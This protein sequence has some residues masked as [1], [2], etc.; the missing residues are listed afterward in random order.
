VAPVRVQVA[1]ARAGLGSRRACDALVAQG[2]VTVNG[3]VA[4]LGTKADPAVDRIL[5]RGKPLRAASRLRYVV[6]FKPRGLVTTVSDPEGRPTVMDL[7]AGIRERLHPV[8]RLDVQT[9]GLLLLTNDGPL[10]D[11]LTHPRHGVTKTYLAKVSG[12]LGANAVRRLADGIPLHG[13]RTA[14]IHVRTLKRAATSSWVEVVV[15]EGRKHLVREVL[16]A[17]GHPVSKLRRVAFGPL[18]L[19]GLEPGQW[20]DLTP[21]EVDRLRRAATA[22]GG[23]APRPGRPPAPRRRPSRPA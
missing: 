14:P 4:E 8:G 16:L 2:L 22:A 19:K 23:A 17:V 6:L 10:T 3:K 18:R 12:E 9:D 5:V 21:A 13:R 20:R 11:A 1:L 7:L 15:R